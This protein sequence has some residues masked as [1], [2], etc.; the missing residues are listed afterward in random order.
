LLVVATMRRFHTA[1][2][3]YAQEAVA[4][5][6]AYWITGYLGI[7]KIAAEIGTEHLCIRSNEVYPPPANLFSIES[8]LSSRDLEP[9]ARGCVQCAG[10]LEGEPPW[11]LRYEPSEPA[12][13]QF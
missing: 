13:W 10:R 2:L 12:S 7:W 1:C 6:A 5:A 3:S 8:C 4:G 9:G 11:G